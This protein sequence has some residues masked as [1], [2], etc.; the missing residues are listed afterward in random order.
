MYNK[1]GFKTNLNYFVEQEEERKKLQL[2]FEHLRAN[3]NKQCNILAKIKKN[4]EDFSDIFG[5][6]LTNEKILDDMQMCYY[7]QLF[8]LTHATHH[9]VDQVIFH[10]LY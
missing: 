7:E 1:M 9:S 10:Y 8:L 2:E 5:E 3:C 6:I 4:G